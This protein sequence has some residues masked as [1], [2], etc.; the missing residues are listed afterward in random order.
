MTVGRADGWTVGAFLRVIALAVLMLLGSVSGRA[1]AQARGAD[2][3]ARVL[4]AYR[5]NDATL[6]KFIT[7]TRGMAAVA[8]PARDTAEA[9]EEENPESIAEIA[10]FYDQHPPYQRAL[11]GAGLT[12]REYVTFMLALFQAGMAAWLVEQHGW[13]RL[14]PDI[15]RANVVFYQ[16]HKAQLDSVT[17]ELK[18]REDDPP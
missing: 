18:N 13:D 4:A 11:S 1:A 3:D 5:L 2:P 6:G 8:R 12:S 9:E 16:R 10:A 14:P 7:A 17:A 15:A